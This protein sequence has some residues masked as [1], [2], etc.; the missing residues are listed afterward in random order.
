MSGKIRI[1]GV[2][3]NPEIGNKEANLNKVKNLLMKI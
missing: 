1:L 2:Q 3:I